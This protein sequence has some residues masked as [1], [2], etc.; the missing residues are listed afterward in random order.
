M[1]KSSILILLLTVMILTISAVGA[2][3]TNVTSDLAHSQLA[4][5][6]VALALDD[7][8]ANVVLNDKN[9]ESL[10]IDGD[11]NFTAL[12]QEIDSGYV[13]LQKD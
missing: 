7:S 8:D 6:S 5:D 3:D 2:A 13:D 12:Q 1:K 10:A 9:T 4:D 11:N